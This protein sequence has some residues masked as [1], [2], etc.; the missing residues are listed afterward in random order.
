MGQGKT[1]GRRKLT[2]VNWLS[3]Y[4]AKAG[5]GMRQW[6]IYSTS[7]QYPGK[8]IQRLPDGTEAVGTFQ[9]G[10]FV[11]EQSGHAR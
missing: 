1:Q 6:P 7:T 3:M 8:L 11:P 2:G 10:S 5:A 4:D 9:N